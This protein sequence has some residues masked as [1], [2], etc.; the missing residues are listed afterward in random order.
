MDNASCNT[1]PSKRKHGRSRKYSTSEAKTAVD[2]ERRRARRQNAAPV[3]RDT[4]HA[5]CHN[6]NPDPSQVNT[7]DATLETSPQAENDEAGPVGHL[8]Q[9]LAEQLVKF[10]GCCN[11]CHRAAQLEHME[12]PNEQISLAMYLEFVPELGPDVLGTENIARQKDDLAGKMSPE[13]RRK[14]FCGLESR[15]KMSHICLDEDER[16]SNDAGVTFDVDSIIAFPSNL[17]VAKRGICWSP[18]RMTASNLQ[19]DLHLRSIPVT[20][21]DTNGRQHQ[22]HRPVHQ[23]PHHTFGCVVGLEDAS[24]YF[25]FPNLHREEQKCSKIRDEEF[26]FCYSVIM[27][28]LSH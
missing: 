18:T 4:V 26:L 25:L 6:P 17:A 5:N 27:L 10:Q 24:L 22:V 9:Q 8:A 19:S 12:D 7:F 20:Y 28:W 23:I 13:S 15:V 14:A 1:V 16:V 21:S 3:Q 2:V 11:D